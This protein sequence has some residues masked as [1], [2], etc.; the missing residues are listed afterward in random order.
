[1]TNPS[2]HDEFIRLLP[3]VVPKDAL[4]QLAT[5]WSERQRCW[6]GPEH[7]L[8][9]LRA[10]ASRRDITGVNRD[11]L[12][13][14]VAY[15]DAVYDPRATDN[16][17]ASAAL[18][19]RHMGS[20]PSARRAAEAIEAS[21]WARRPGNA[22]EQALFDLDTV[23]L[24]DA[25]D[26]TARIVYERAIAREYQWVPRPVYVAKRTEFLRGWA[27]RFPEHAR[28]VTQC[29][30]LLVALV[31]RVALYPGSFD[32]F[33]QGHLSIL[34]QAEA[35]FDKVI[36]AVGVNRQKAAGALEA[37]QQLISA[38]LPY[39]EVVAF[40][41]LLSDLLDSLGMPVNVVR[42]VRDGTDLE[43]ELRYARFLNELRPGTP[44][45][46]IGC[47]P[48]LQHVSSSAVR[49]LAAI[50]PGAE[51]RYVP[52]AAQIYGLPHLAPATVPPAKLPPKN[53]EAE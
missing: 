32:P 31:P 6:H 18:L 43:S 53:H 9:M 27:E 16:E 28:G 36:V 34:R 49:E 1:M 33:H 13:L 40:G 39:H 46:W 52:D 2:L 45:V 47:E 7:V 35:T 29:L 14:A 25:C 26:M 38:Q 3:P 22:L 37:R 30:E 21:T 15:H 11:A 44:V 24:S 41:G 4:A 20:T 5:C 12:R 23:T 42:G 50:Q 51:A 8:T 19:L 48:G 17:Q 10:V